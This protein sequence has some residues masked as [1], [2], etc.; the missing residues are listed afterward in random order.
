MVP[1]P[2]AREAAALPGRG[3]RRAPRPSTPSGTSTGGGRSPAP[4]RC[5]TATAGS[6]HHRGPV[7]P[8]RPR[9]GPPGAVGPRSSGPSCGASTSATSTA[10]W[11]AS[12]FRPEFFDVHPRPRRRVRPA[13]ADDGRQ[14]REERRLPVPPAG[15]RGGRGLPRP[16]HLP[17]R[18]HPA[19]ARAGHRR[20]AAGR[21]RAVP[22]PGRRHAGAAGA[23]PPTG[24]SR[25][26]DHALVTEADRA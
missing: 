16:P 8:R 18:P 6:P 24:R 20:P 22:P 3:R 7:G 21:H 26:D 4:R 12:S 17:G 15:R 19:P 9:R 10:T 13:H 11:A 5:T 2:W 25:V 14:L 23:S 1:G